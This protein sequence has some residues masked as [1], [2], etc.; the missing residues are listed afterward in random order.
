MLTTGFRPHHMLTSKGD[1]LTFGLPH[2]GFAMAVRRLQPR[3]L[4]QCLSTQSWRQ[5]CLSKLREF[6]CAQTTIQII[7]SCGQD[8]YSVDYVLSII[9]AA[10][11]VLIHQVR[12]I[13][14]KDV[15]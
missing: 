5:A 8:N 12:R 11:D 13:V 4:A 7:S 10:N 9:S 3:Q 2:G 15:G 6:Q 14:S 1:S